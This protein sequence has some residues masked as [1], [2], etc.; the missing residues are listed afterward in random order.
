M[1]A[2]EAAATGAAVLRSGPGTNPELERP[3]ASNPA[4]TTQAVT[5]L[6]ERAIRKR[7]RGEALGQKYAQSQKC[8]AISKCPVQQWGD[9]VLAQPLHFRFT[10]SHE[11]RQKSSPL[12]LQSDKEVN[13]NLAATAA[14]GGIWPP[15][16]PQRHQTRNFELPQVPDSAL[17][18]PGFC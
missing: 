18:S 11:A 7:A 12:R 14:F 16:S 3:H 15:Q 13:T 4:T 8:F 9:V 2:A 1:P 6:V 17:R 10:L 5:F